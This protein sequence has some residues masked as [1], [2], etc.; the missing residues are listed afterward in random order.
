MEG[1]GEWFGIVKEGLERVLEDDG[2]N[3]SW[4]YDD[5]VEG[6]EGLEEGD[7]EGDG[8]EEEEEREREWIVGMDLRE[9]EMGGGR[10]G[11]VSAGGGGATRALEI[12]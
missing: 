6:E 12:R 9:F 4:Q 5:D 11:G 8:E 7:R 2:N 1:L 10:R 3:H